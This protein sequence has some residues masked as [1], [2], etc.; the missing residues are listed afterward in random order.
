MKKLEIFAKAFLFCAVDDC[1][2]KCPSS[3]KTPL[4]YKIPCYTPV[5]VLLSYFQR[6]KQRWENLILKKSLNL[7]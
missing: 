2:L 5:K 4:P 7:S 1:L 6:Q 3:N